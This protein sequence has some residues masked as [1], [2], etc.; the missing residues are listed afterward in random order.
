MQHLYFFNT[1]CLSEEM[2]DKNYEHY[3]L[4]T[5]ISQNLDENLKDSHGI[6]LASTNASQTHGLMSDVKACIFLS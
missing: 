3:D 5:R 2:K 4:M 1:S 6:V